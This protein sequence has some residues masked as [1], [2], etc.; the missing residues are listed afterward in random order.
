MIE[1]QQAVTS[2]EATPRK[3]LHVITWG[4]QMNVYDSGRMSDVLAPLGYAA[5]DTP[6]GADMVILNTCHIRD[7]AAEKVF[8]ELG[9]LRRLKEATRRADDPGGRRLR[10]AGRGPRNP[11]PRAVCRHRTGPAD[12]SPAA[13]DGGSG[14]PRRRCGHRNGVSGRGQVR[15]PARAARSPGRHRVPDGAGGLRQVLQL[16]R[17]A[18]HPRRRTEPAR[19]RHPGR[20]PAADRPGVA[21]DHVTRAERQCVAWRRAGRRHLGSRRVAARH[22]R[23]S[24]AAAAALRDLASARHGRLR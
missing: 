15:P 1:T 5:A 11:R 2:P 8:S 24:R 10:G 20:G 13:G 7:K 12:L 22:G 23:D 16:L 9:R 21:R 17:R 6:D 18:L 4:C 3:R 19:R 14:G